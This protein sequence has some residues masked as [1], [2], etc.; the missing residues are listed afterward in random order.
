MAGILSI[1]ATPIGNLED[2]TLR[3]LRTLR[4]CDLIAAEDTRRTSGLIAHYEIRKPLVSLREHNEA[5]ESPKLVARMA[6]G[7]HV[8]LVTDAGTPTISDPGSRL[9]RLA[10]EH[11]IRIE[12]IPGPNAA[13]TALSASGLDVSQFSFL[14]YP[15]PSGSSRTRWMSD[16]ATETRP[17]VFYEAPHRIR[18][19]TADV[20][21]VVKRPIIVMRELTKLHE[22]LVICSTVED[23]QALK[24]LGEFVLVVQPRDPLA[25]SLPESSASDELVRA[26]LEA[27]TGKSRLNLSQGA[28][29]VAQL[30]GR[31]P[32]EIKRIVKSYAYIGHKTQNSGR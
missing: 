16:L 31:K 2:I 4:E 12:P 23:A 6:E 8:A 1:V 9:V 14:G 26:V 19:T 20:L 24:Q 30:T 32:S 3:A 7:A 18:R 10:R 25:D 17:V 13:V 21:T 29:L 28:E 5:R 11:G 22:E 27:T 15:P